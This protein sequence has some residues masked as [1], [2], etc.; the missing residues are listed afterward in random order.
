MAK[1]IR[2]A[3]ASR[4]R[5]DASVESIEVASVIMAVLKQSRANNQLTKIGGA[6]YY[7]DGFF[8]QCLEGEESAVLSLVEKIRTDPR[9][10]QLKVSFCKRIRKRYFNSWTMTYVPMSQAVNEFIESRGYTTFTPSEFDESDINALISLFAKLDEESD[11]DERLAASY[12]LK[13]HWWQRLGS[14]F[15]A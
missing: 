15:G 11:R 12:K 13:L 1:L 5:F 7:A 9:H 3:Y 2:L 8:F 14:V 10:E 6:L 4:A